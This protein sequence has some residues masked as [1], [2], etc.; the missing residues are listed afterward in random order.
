LVDQ[1][2]AGSLLANR[3]ALLGLHGLN[4][5]SALSGFTGWRLA[6]AGGVQFFSQLRLF[7]GRHGWR[8]PPRF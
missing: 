2:C 7:I 5:R 4:W 1:H 3:R 8:G 6:V